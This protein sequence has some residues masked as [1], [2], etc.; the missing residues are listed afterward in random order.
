MI[1]SKTALAVCSGILAVLLPLVLGINYYLMTVLII[2][3]VFIIYSSAWNFLALSGQGSLG[4]AAF[5]GLGGYA[6]AILAR[7]LELPPL[8]TILLGGIFAACI[9]VL[10]GLTCVRL[11]EWFLAMVTFGFAVITHTITAE[12]SWLT[13]GWDGI[14]AKKLVP[15]TIPNYIVYEYYILLFIA[16]A[17]IL[18]LYLITRSRV[19]LALEAIRENELEAKVM[20][21]NVTRYKLTAFAV[22]AFLTGIAGAL[23]IHH[24]GYITPEVYGI[25]ISF[26]PIIYCISGGLFTLEGPI[27]GTV[28]ITIL[29]EGLKSFGWTYE[30]LIL[31][32]VILI[33]VVIF[34]PK[35]FVSIPN[36]LKSRLKSHA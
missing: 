16:G 29:S 21:I 32:G 31:I 4:H 14:P 12:L 8:A 11:R 6:S 25:D 27:L 35:G 1:R 26:W 13:G 2:M 22:S 10:I 3:L 36:K 24:F 18:T 9:G 15:V 23:E 33:L 20:G 5:F 17:V 34:L 30:R 28:I 7:S 19:G